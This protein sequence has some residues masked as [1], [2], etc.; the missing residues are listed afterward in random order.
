MSDEEKKA[1]CRKPPRVE[2]RIT[3]A[4]AIRQIYWCDFWG[5]AQ[6][7]EMWKRRPV[8]VISFRHTLH[9]H[10]LV[11]ACSTDPQE[12]KAA[13]WA[14]ELSVSLDGQTTYVVCN[15][16]YTVATSR[17]TLDRTGVVRLS[18]EEFNLILA[19]VLKWLPRLPEQPAA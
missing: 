4:P 17:L 2:P 8:V 13:E 6:L 15:H 18:E 12:G 10:C 7:P 14:H 1:A 19:K 11:A 3:A 5:D 16:L 9:G